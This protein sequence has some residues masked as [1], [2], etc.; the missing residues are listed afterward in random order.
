MG[1]TPEEIR[2]RGHPIWAEIDLAAIRHNVRTLAGAAPGAELMGV[3]KGYAYGHGNP[4]AAQA[5]VEGGAT[6]LGVARLAE[7]IHLREA[8]VDVPIHLFTEPPLDGIESL[9]EHRLTP[10]VYTSDFARVLSQRAEEL[11]IRIPVHIKLDT[12]MH[13]VGILADD[14]PDAVAEISALPGLKVEGAWSHLAVAD[15]IDH[16]HT[17]KQLDLFAELLDRIERAGIDLRFR[18]IANSAATMTLPDS[19]YDMVRCGIAAYG[20]SPGRGFENLLELRP[21]MSLRARVAMTKT[22][23]A[24]DALSYGLAYELARTSNVV[25]VAAGYADGYDRRLSGR[26]DVLI[27]GRR[28]KVSG[29]VCMDQFMVDIGDHSV[30]VGGV[31]TLMGRDGDSAITAEELAAL[32]GTI[33]YEVTTRVPSRVPRLYIDREAE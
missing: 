4:Q 26:A 21:A 2:H 17:R 32:I 19:H 9:V 18:H 10:T 15:V 29:T 1:L 20:L 7:G 22:V 11:G 5:M 24:G 14:V 30:P 3:V 27:E 28:F 8:G 25:T 33:N 16:P 6:R 31:V 23:P 12:G 13:R